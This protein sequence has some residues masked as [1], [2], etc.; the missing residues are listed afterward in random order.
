MPPPPPRGAKVPFD[1]RG[2]GHASA[3]KR[4]CVAPNPFAAL[5]SAV[6][7]AD[8]KIWADGNTVCTPSFKKTWDLNPHSVPAVTPIETVESIESA[9]PVE[10]VEQDQL[11]V[12]EFFKAHVKRTEEECASELAEPQ[13]SDKWKKARKFT[14]T[15]SAAAA[16][17]DHAPMPRKYREYYRLLLQR[18]TGGSRIVF[19][20]EIEAAN[21]EDLE[22]VVRDSGALVKR[23]NAAWPLHNPYSSRVKAIHEKLHVPFVG[24]QMTQWGN[25]HEDDAAAVYMAWFRDYLRQK[26]R[27][28]GLN[29]D[30]A[31]AIHKEYGLIKFSQEPW[32]GTSVD[33]ILQYTDVDGVEKHVLLEFKCPYMMFDA[34]DHPY[35]KY[36]HN[37]PPYY[38]DQIQGSMGLLN[39]AIEHGWTP[40]VK[41]L[42]PIRE[43]HFVV[44][45]PRQT[46]ITTHAYDHEYFDSVMWPTLQK[47]YYE[48]FLPAATR[49]YN[50]NSG[51]QSKEPFLVDI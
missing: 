47:S 2:G 45:Q 43:C 49:Q 8:D 46:W 41:G 38:Y 17:M 21:A 12:S 24:N 32:I 16:L 9:K 18:S 35:G 25:N 10:P 36:P 40:S 1:F 19:P 23:H 11:S 34:D 13:R 26:Y 20:D 5:P 27:D 7:V 22:A 29:P 15:M 37:T 30:D 6:S 51:G 28:H 48:H 42:T 33:G 50:S 31:V 3:S 44:W 39:K 14:F 4:T